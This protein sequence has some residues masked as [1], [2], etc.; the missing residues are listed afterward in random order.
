MLSENH[1]TLSHPPR[2]SVTR[3]VEW[4]LGLIAVVTS[5]AGVFIVLQQLNGIQYSGPMLS[6]LFT[7]LWPLPSL[8]LIGWVLLSLVG[9]WG[10]ALDARMASSLNQNG[11][12]LTGFAGGALLALALLGM[13]SIGPLVL[14][15]ALALTLAACLAALRTRHSIGRT[16]LAVLI[17][18][19]TS[20]LLL[21]IL[22][23]SV[24]WSS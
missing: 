21:V 7:D 2:Q 15:A 5:V 13:F 6:A 22:I 20:F 11:E 24:R 4:L 3:I 18:A 23:I 1:E 9:L 8:V 14:I 17:G 12:M 16:L 19:A 10:I